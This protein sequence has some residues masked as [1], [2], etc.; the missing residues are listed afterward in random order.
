MFRQ[1]LNLGFVKGQTYKLQNKVDEIKTGVHVS[2][3]Y[4]RHFWV[5]LRDPNPNILVQVQ[6]IK[7]K[8]I[9]DL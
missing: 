2:S 6:K 4:I 1:E 5:L 7:K 9:P 8:M 3:F